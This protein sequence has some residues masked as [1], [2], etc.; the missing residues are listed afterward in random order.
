MNDNK[1]KIK[2][3]ENLTMYQ[4]EKPLPLESMAFPATVDPTNGP[5]MEKI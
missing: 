5:L 1:G 3:I 4:A 2:F